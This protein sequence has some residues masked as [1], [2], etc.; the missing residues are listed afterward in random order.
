MKEK[1]KSKKREAGRQPIKSQPAEV[2]MKFPSSDAMLKVV[3]K[4]KS[5]NVKHDL[6]GQHTVVVA[7][8]VAFRM[9]RLGFRFETLNVVYLVDL[10]AK[11]QKKLREGM[12]REEVLRRMRLARESGFDTERM[13]EVLPQT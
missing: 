1:T 7:P 2:G 3:A 6:A 11:K 8:N 9:K 13:K 4:L 5:L 12:S 10:P